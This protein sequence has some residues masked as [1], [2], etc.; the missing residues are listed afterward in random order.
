[1]RGLNEPNA[2]MSTPLFV[3]I[4]IAPELRA[5]VNR[6]PKP[7][8]VTVGL[9]LANPKIESKILPVDGGGLVKFSCVS[10][11]TGVVAVVPVD[12]TDCGT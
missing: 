9:F 12:V 2:V 10:I 11:A 4:S 1:M 8:P 5:A 3:G 6:A 7:A